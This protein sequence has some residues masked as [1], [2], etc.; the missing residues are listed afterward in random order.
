MLPD[1]DDDCTT[2]LTYDFL[3]EK[4]S[5]FKSPC[6]LCI[7]AIPPPSISYPLPTFLYKKFLCKSKKQK[8]KQKLPYS[9]KINSA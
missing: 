5:I 4:L 9:Y 6:E 2:L 7:E 8:Q 1:N 3:Q